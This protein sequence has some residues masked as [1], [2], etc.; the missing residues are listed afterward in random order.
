M[1]AASALAFA[2][3]GFALILRDSKTSIGQ[4]ICEAFSLATLLIGML[5]LIGYAYGVE[6]LYNFQAY[7]SMALHTAFLCPRIRRFSS[8][9]LKEGC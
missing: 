3:L 1:A 5:T 7:R 8:R 4:I 2:L 9:A 6:S